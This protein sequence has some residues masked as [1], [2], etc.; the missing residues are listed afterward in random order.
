MKSLC[1]ECGT[2]DVVTVFDSETTMIQEHKKCLVCGHGW[3]EVDSLLTQWWKKR[4][5]LIT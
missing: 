1:S 4:Q 5:W 3:I 2:Y